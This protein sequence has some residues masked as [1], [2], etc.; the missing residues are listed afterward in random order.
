M[1]PAV[2]A[3]IGV[4]ALVLIA[5]LLM[6]K[7]KPKA[8]PREV[9]AV[10]QHWLVQPEEGG[11][12]SWHIG[13][14]TVTIGRGPSNFVQVATPGV[15]RM[16]CQLM[17]TADGLK[18]VDMTSHNGTLVNGSAVAEHLLADRDVIGAGEASFVYRAEGDFGEN[19]GF[20]AK[21]AGQ[22]T[23]DP[24]NI[25]GATEHNKLMTAHMTFAE[26]DQDHEKAAGQ[27]GISVDELKELL[28][29]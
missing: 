26:C 15:S 22:S 17:P 11:G 12:T 4:L 5:L 19:A 16:H 29:N 8:T 9:P 1:H 18:L 28:D 2:I 27:L 10:K 25:V 21:V 6:R 23:L 7:P 14:R 3:L 13:Q 24:T 20:A